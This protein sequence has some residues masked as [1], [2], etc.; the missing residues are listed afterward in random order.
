M[1]FGLLGPLQVSRD[2]VELPVRGGKLRK[3]LV[4]LLLDA[5]CRVPADRLVAALWE[6]KPREGV[7]EQSCACARGRRSVTPGAAMAEQR[8]AGA[9]PS[10]GSIGAAA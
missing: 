8:Q 7:A 9:A 2:G 3:L 6:V 4:A 5:G 1:R 10:P